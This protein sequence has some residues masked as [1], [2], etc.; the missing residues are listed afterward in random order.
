MQLYKLQ[1]LLVGEGKALYI[2]RMRWMTV[3]S[4]SVFFSP[5]KILSIFVMQVFL[6]IVESVNLLMSS[7]GS[8]WPQSSICITYLLWK[9]ITIGD[10]R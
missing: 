3:L 1:V 9:L 10:H 7:K 4:L 6:D 2:K 8:E 5:N